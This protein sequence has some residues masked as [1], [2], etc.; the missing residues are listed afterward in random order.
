LVSVDPD[1]GFSFTLNRRGR[2]NPSSTV[3][4]H[5]GMRRCGDMLLLDDVLN[6]FRWHAAR[7]EPLTPSGASSQQ[8][9]PDAALAD[10]DDP[11]WPSA[12]ISVVEALWGEGFLFPGGAAE[13]SRHAALQRTLAFG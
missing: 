3:S 13:T 11:S 5:P 8:R 4:P 12:R 9:V 2:L 10:D 1:A 6:L 7:V